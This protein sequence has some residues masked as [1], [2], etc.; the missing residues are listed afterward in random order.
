MFSP[1]DP[2][3]ELRDGDPQ[4]SRGSGGDWC[5][6]GKH[7]VL[8][9]CVWGVGVIRPLGHLACRPHSVKKNASPEYPSD[10]S[11]PAHSADAGQ[12]RCIRRHDLPIIGRRQAVTTLPVAAYPAVAGRSCHMSCARTGSSKGGRRLHLRGAD[13]GISL[14]RFNLRQ[15]LEAAARGKSWIC[16]SPSFGAPNIFGRGIRANIHRRDLSLSLAVGR[17]VLSASENW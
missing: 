6:R 11:S 4:E 1:L 17:L 3:L 5:L 13:G 7:G 15:R 14:S 2:E 8:G 16:P 9:R 12:I 10:S